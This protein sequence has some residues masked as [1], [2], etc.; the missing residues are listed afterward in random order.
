MRRIGWV[1]VV[2]PA[3]QFSQAKIE[4]FGLATLGHKYICGLDIAMNDAFGVRR[5]Q[6][7]GNLNT[8]SQN[9]FDRKRLAVVAI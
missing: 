8:Q 1:F 3:D 5:V 9:F 4:D 6:R 7:I 2:A